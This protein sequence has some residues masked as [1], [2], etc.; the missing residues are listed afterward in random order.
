MRDWFPFFPEDA[1][2][3]S[4]SV[5]EFFLFLV[6]MS[7]FFI[8]VIAGL[9]IYFA[10]R[11]RRRSPDEVPRPMRGAV[12][13][14]VVWIVVP[15]MLSMVIFG[16]GA[17]LYFKM[18][19][20]PDEGMEIY[21]VGKQWMWKLQ[22]MSGRREI[23]ELH[24]P[25]GRK[26]KLTMA[27][28]D[29]IHNFFVPAFRVKADVIPG[30]YTALWFEAKKSGRYHLFCAEYCGTNHSRMIGW[31]HVMEPPDFQAWLADGT[32]ETGL[33]ASG[34]NLFR[35]FACDSCHRPGGSGRA[36]QLDG[37][38]DRSV[39]LDSGEIVIADEDYLRESILD[40]QAEIVAGFRRPSIMPVFRGQ[41]S[42][43]QLLQLI[44]YIKS[45]ERG[46]QQG[47]ESPGDVPVPN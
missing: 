28:E 38:F 44:V 42:E 4:S 47:E 39:A 46:S 25:L 24:V 22:H 5:D 14:E 23:N 13:L 20:M 27:S 35:E 16:W 8:V 10:L 34:E 3:L 45:M 40:S 1:S 19:R 7:L 21:V 41:I 12:R 31:V 6:G 26:I 2:T 17:S 18:Y 9:E 11:Y 29:V 37:V 43:E 15:L 33:V 32:A 36:P 30:R